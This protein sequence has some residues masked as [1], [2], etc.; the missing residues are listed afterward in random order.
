[1]AL[2]QRA[3]F[4]SNKG[5]LLP[6]MYYSNLIVSPGFSKLP[7]MCKHFSV[8]IRLG[9]HS[10]FVCQNETEQINMSRLNPVITSFEIRGLNDQYLYQRHVLQ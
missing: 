8:S 5:T 9:K 1:M 7:L 6:V 3:S 2:F 10:V 4:F